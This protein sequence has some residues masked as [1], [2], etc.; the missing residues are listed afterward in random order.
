MRKI[1]YF[2][3]VILAATAPLLS[4]QFDLVPNKS[5][6]EI[7]VLKLL[8]VADKG[9]RNYMADWRKEITDLV[10]V[11]SQA[12]DKQTGIQLKIIG[13]D[14]WEKEM[15][16]YRGPVLPLKELT[17]I[18]PRTKDANFDII[19]GLSSDSEDYQGCAGI[20]AAYIIIDCKG[21]YYADKDRPKVH[22][23]LSQEIRTKI[24]PSIII[25]EIGHL[26]GC[27]DKKE[28]GSVMFEGPG[29]Y[30]NLFYKDDIETIKKN[31]WRKFPFFPK[32]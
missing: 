25:H 5:Q 29:E 2:L 26:F 8:I 30:S 10:N 12:L 15:Q 28:E 22:F 19:M 4:Q 9:Y 13:F 27:K 16:E 21:K 17:K 1:R 18:F 20:Y 6:D 31:K 32:N 3:I 11:A 14:N 24:F 7:R 23:W